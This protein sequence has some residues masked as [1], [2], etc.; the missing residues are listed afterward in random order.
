MLVLTKLIKLIIIM[1]ALY[2]YNMRIISLFG[3]M[4]VLIKS[5]HCCPNS[6]Q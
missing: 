4:V 3:F 2:I 5:R 6:S 1:K